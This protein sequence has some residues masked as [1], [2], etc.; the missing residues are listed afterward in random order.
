[1]GVSIYQL[2]ILIYSYMKNY[3]SFINENLLKDFLKK[4]F[5]QSLTFLSKDRQEIMIKLI[6]SI[7]NKKSFI[8]GINSVKNVFKNIEQTKIDNINSLKTSINDDLISIDMSLKTLSKKFGTDELL[9]K[10]FYNESNNKILKTAL[11][12]D[13]EKDFLKNLPFNS[14]QLLFQILKTAGLDDQQIKSLLKTEQ[15]NE[16]MIFE[17]QD[18]QHLQNTDK[19]DDTINDEEQELSDEENDE[20]KENDKSDNIDFTKI[21]KAYTDFQQNAIFIPLIKE[22]DKFNNEREIEL[23]NP[24]NF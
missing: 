13:N 2:I 21:Q 19:L 17:L 8:D 4:A 22:L 16:S 3:D 20:T 7:N 14:N 15:K 18:V 12:Y 5:A 1:M 24:K 6:D 10:N 9:P 11:I 23:K